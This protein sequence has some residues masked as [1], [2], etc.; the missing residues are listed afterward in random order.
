MQLR[1]ASEALV[2]TAPSPNGPTL[3]VFF[4]GGEGD[5]P[6]LGVLR[7]TVPPGAGMPPHRH[8]GSDV[9]LVPTAGRV[10]IS[11]GEEEIEVTLGDAALI[12]REEE[13]ALTNPDATEAQVIVAAGPADF[14]SGI[15]DWP[16]PDPE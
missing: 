7:V 10:V 13:V 16:T 9:I 15:R 2:R 6:D 11:K 5:S 8:N 1:T 14:V 4:G 3:A 12:G